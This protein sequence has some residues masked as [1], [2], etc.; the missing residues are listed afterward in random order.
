ME[1]GC[2]YCGSDNG[3]IDHLI[4][5]C[6]FFQ[7]AREEADKELAKVR[8]KMLL[9]CPEE[10]DCSDDDMLANGD[11]L[12]WKLLDPTPGEAKLLGVV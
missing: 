2:T 4:W 8:A 5:T 6:C 11:L 12:G 10:R 3:S 7:P 1:E 9:P